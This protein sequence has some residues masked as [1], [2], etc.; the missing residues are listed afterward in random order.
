M[1]RKSP[2]KLLRSMIDDADGVAF[3]RLGSHLDEMAA[4][5]D[6]ALKAQYHLESALNEALE[7]IETQSDVM[8][9]DYGQPEANRAMTLA[10]D[11]KETLGAVS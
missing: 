11:I 6:R 1:S 4:V 10:R 9:G 7:F 3:G 2:L 5:C 8:D